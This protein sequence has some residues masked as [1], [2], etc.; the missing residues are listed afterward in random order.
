MIQTFKSMCPMNCF[1]TYCGME[2]DVENGRV[3]KIRGDKENPDSRGFLCLR[4]AS[5]HEVVNHPERLKVPLLRRRIGDPWQEVSWSQALDVVAESIESAGKDKVGIWPGHGILVNSIG[6]Q[7]ALRFGRTLGCQAWSGVMKCWTLGAFG[8]AL[9]G[10]LEV[11]TKE[12]MAAHS[13]CVFL[14]GANF[15]SQPNSIRSI[16]AAKRRGA[17]LVA[18]DCRYTEACRFSDRVVLLRPG[19]DAALALAMMNVLIGERLY[20]HAFV[21]AHTVGF[22]ELARHVEDKT[23]EWAEGISGVPAPTVRELARLYATRAPSMIVLGG[24]SMFKHTNGWLSGRAIS[25]LPALIGNLG[26]PGGGFGPRHGGAT[27][28]EVLGTLVER[29]PSLL[30]HHVPSQMSRILQALEEGPIRVLFLFGTDMVS[31]FAESHRVEKALHALDLVVVYDLFMNETAK[32]AHL[33]LPATTWLEEVGYKK[34]NTHVYLMDQAIEP[35]G[36]ARPLSWILKELS[37]RLGLRDFF[38]WPSQEEAVDAILNVPATGHV[39]GSELR[40]RGGREHLRI[41]PVAHPDLRFPT[42]SGKVEFYSERSLKWGLP[43]LPEYREPLET[44]RSRPEVARRFPLV[45]RPGRTFGH[46]NNFYRNGRAIRRLA[47]RE[48]EP[49]VWLHPEDAASRGIQ[50]RQRVMVFNDRSEFQGRAKVSARMF[51]GT[52]WVRTGWPGLNALTVCAPCL[53]DEAVEGVGFPAGQAAH[54]ALVEVKK[55]V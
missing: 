55:L 33:V 21:E 50:E 43:P 19:T 24:S 39:T 5:V 20:D 35:V 9:T 12:D 46:F 11:N 48:S 29:R 10:V 27:H 49:V 42:P 8:L 4:G 38:P 32:H 54:E 36:Q 40:A 53:P 18:L 52:V 47:L 15:P 34:T 2:V 37:V 23:P 26:I 44:P 3:V 17:T 28:D 14:W 30:T 7:L 22:P 51:P 1:P 41:S 25:C 6:T 31:S 45:L 16:L 13:K